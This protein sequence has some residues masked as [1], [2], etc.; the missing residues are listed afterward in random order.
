M[1]G[2][3]NRVAIVTG[4]AGGI[5][6]AICQRFIEEGI[7]II[8]V[9]INDGALKDLVASLGVDQSRLIPVA[10]DITDYQRVKGRR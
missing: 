10:V 6:R 8:A 9:D 3:K 1:R 7:N 5:G 4:A 2:L